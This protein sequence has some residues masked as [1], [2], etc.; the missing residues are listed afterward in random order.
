MK[1]P[2]VAVATLL[3]LL[4]V[5]AGC[6]AEDAR[7]PADS[8]TPAAG[9][10]SPV[11]SDGGADGAARRPT[12]PPPSTGLYDGPPPA[13]VET[14]AGS[15]WLAFASYCWE[16]VCADA[17]PPRCGT[18]HAAEIEVAPREG[19]V[20]HL[21]FEPTAVT[22]RFFGDPAD[23]SALEG[24]V[25]LET[26]RDPVW[27]IDRDG[28]V[29]LSAAGADGRDASYAACLR[30]AADNG[31]GAPSAEPLTVEQA[32]AARTTQPLTVVGTL[33]VNGDE[34]RLCGLV[35]ESFPPQCPSRFLLVEGYD[36][37]AGEGLTREGTIAWIDRPVELR[38]RIRGTTLHVGG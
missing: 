35:A 11:S 38:G 13:W 6:G 7:E 10:D 26:R 22:L 21:G 5:V 16:T 20:F 33:L 12:S 8:S 34:V 18:A 2:A 36:P 29:W 23:G 31:A 28:P 32:A 24:E 15:V 14:S 30:F 25:L 27:E 1:P 9:P 3:T 17:M 19:L 37:A 4:A